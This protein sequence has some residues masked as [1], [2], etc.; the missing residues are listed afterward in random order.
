MKSFF[1]T[2]TDTG[3]GKTRITL[4]LMTVLK[5]RGLRVMGMKPV[6]TGCVLSPSGPRNQ[7]AE[8][9][10]ACCGVEMPY[11]LINPYAFVPPIAPLFAARAIQVRID[12]S[13]IVKAFGALSARADTVLVEG[14]GGWRIRLGKDLQMSDLVRSLQLRV[15]L[16]VGLR[17]GCI[18]H[19]LL[20]VAAVRNDGL[21]LAGW[22]ANHIDPGYDHIEETVKL[23]SEEIPAP[24]IGLTPFSVENDNAATAACLSTAGMEVLDG[25]G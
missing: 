22:I 21:P 20:S 8:M 11:E 13:E 5:Q 2:G 24:M 9:I 3:V 17:L 14:V 12:K 7:D 16:V 1:I 15:I 19:A 10:R 6:A 18:N 25:G 23:L 4:A